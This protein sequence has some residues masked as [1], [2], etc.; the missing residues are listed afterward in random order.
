MKVLYL[1]CAMG[2]AGD[3]LAAAL[4]ELLPSPEAFL[5]RVNGLGI[6]GVKI[7]AKNAEKCGITGT[8][9]E[10]SF[11]GLV[12]GGES[13]EH[14]GHG[15]H[16]MTIAEI[17]N[18]LEGF[19]LSEKVKNDVKSV[20]NILAQAESKVHNTSVDNIHFHELG[21]MDA[22]ADIVCVCMLMEEL[23]P[24]AI[25][26]SSVNVGGGYVKCAHGLL[27]VPAPATAEILK[28]IPVYS[29][30]IKSELCTPT[31]AALLKYFVSEFMNMPEMTA[32]RIGYGMGTKNFPVPNCVRAFYGEARD[33]GE[34][35]CVL[36]CNLDDMTGEELGFA[37][38]R[39]FDAGALDVYTV[40]VY[41]KKSRPGVMLQCICHSEL[42]EKIVGTMFKYTSTLGIREE[43]CRRYTLNR[44]VVCR[45]TEFG[46]IRIK[47]ANGWG[48]SREKPEY[49]DVSNAAVEYGVTMEEVKKS[50]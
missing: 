22:V 8:H 21:T 9:V 14:H 28:E 48:I 4:L 16:H 29:G 25:Y 10:V 17:F 18:A 26:A 23:S 32:K 49:D 27:P 24:D 50:L 42:K 5:C 30:E 7:E 6:D 12:E 11:H 33:K 43:N 46:R 41:M 36:S 1:D 45:E 35:V 38:N 20:F 47:R 15:H 44:E 2:A 39:L 37:G 19:E 40:P 13:D 3:M 34:N 31:G